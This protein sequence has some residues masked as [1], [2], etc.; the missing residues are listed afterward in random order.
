MEQMKTAIRAAYWRSQ[1]AAG[2]MMLAA[3]DAFANYSDPLGARNT[4]G[5]AGQSVDSL[6]QNI[7]NVP[8]LLLSVAQIV[9]IFVGYKA[10]DNWGKVQKGNDPEAK[11]GKTLGYGVAAVGLYFLPSLIGMGGN[12]LL[13]GF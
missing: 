12:T 8:F 9:G 13:P 6:L 2:A 7:T 1:V 3:S 5:D 11:P 4:S 10:F